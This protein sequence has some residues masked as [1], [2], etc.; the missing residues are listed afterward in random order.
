[1][2]KSLIIISAIIALFLHA[3]WTE[4]QSIQLNNPSFEGVPA[5]STTPEGWRDCGKP[6]ETPP[7]TQP[8]RTFR[9]FKKA[10]KGNTYLGLVTRDTDTWEAV[11]QLLETPIDGGECY[12]FSIYLA[13]SD[14]YL[15]RRKTDTIQTQFTQPICFRIWGGNNYCDKREMLAET[16]AIDHT[17]W[18]KYDFKLKPRREYNFITLEAFY[19]T[20][21]LMAYNGNLLL[22]HCS[23]ITL[24]SCND[25]EPIIAKIDDTEPDR[26]I[27]IPPKPR[28]KREKPSKP[29]E[30]TKKE[31]PKTTKETPKEDKPVAIAPPPVKKETPKEEPKVEEA[32]KTNL[33]PEL[34]D[35]NFI[36][37]GQTIQVNSL[38]FPADST[39]LTK[40]SYEVLEE[41]YYFLKQNKKVVIEIGGHT[42]NIPDDD[43]CNKL[44]TARAK[45]VAAHLIQKGIS[46]ERISAKGYGKTRPIASNKT[47]AGRNKNQRVELK[48]ISTGK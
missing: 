4:A 2:Y 17:A 5:A 44:S 40:S 6:G 25:D 29:K 26:N 13:R 36:K 8:N 11:G 39:I 47:Y 23:S 21:T 45:T 34:K 7:D 46:E 24:A 3:T 41:V 32:P 15:S 37:E 38:R 33:L 48:I 35:K 14:S 28:D 1:M 20:P 22:D 12:D 9:V 31:A 19:V 18:K 42:N 16:G 43:Y 10:Q 30:K 27:N